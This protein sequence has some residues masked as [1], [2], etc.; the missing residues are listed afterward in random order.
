MNVKIEKVVTFSSDDVVEILAREAGMEGE[1]YLAH[2]EFDGTEISIYDINK[3]KL[4]S[5]TKS[6][7]K[8]S[9]KLSRQK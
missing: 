7:N 8:L 6:N 4:R 1:L 9:N 2:F 3:I 5:T